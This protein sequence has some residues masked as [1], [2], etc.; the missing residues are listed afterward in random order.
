MVLRRVAGREV[1]GFGRRLPVADRHPRDARR[2]R[3][4]RLEQRRRDRQRAGDV[5]EAVARV[6]RRQQRRDV[7]LEVEQVA[8][9]VGVLGPIQPVQH[10]RARAGRAG[11]VRDRSPLRA[12]R[13]APR[14]RPAAAAARRAAASRRRAACGRPSPTARRGRRRVARSAPR[15]DRF[16]VLTRSLWQVTQYLS[17]SARCV[18]IASRVGGSEDPLPLYRRRHLRG[19]AGE[20]IPA[21]AN[22]DRERAQKAPDGPGHPRHPGVSVARTAAQ[23]KP[24][25][26]YSRAA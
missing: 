11:G 4:V 17:S 16:A 8:N 18:V 19:C 12:S 5:V 22:R 7:D 6:V 3:G 1:G 2:R 25:P 26:R 23:F 13:A 14:T 24:G 9:R 21:R 20:Q 10:H 15:S